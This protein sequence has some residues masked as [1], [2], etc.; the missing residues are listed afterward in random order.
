MTIQLFFL[1]LYSI[2]CLTAI[3]LGVYW[4]HKAINMTKTHKCENGVFTDPNAEKTY[5]SR[6]EK[7]NV[8]AGVFLF[9]SI[10]ATLYIFG[11]WCFLFSLILISWIAFQEIKR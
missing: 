6:K 7:A 8:C 2:I 11:V 9:M 3:T 10:L 1:I 5:N 4:E